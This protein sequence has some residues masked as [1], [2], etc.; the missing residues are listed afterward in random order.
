MASTSVT[1]RIDEDL[2]KH[3]EMLLADMGLNM[4]TAFTLFAKAIIRKGKIP[5]EIAADP[6]FSESNQLYLKRAVAALEAGE[7]IERDLIEAGGI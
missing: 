3:V 1:V 6:F 4:S 7:G 5:F 2:K